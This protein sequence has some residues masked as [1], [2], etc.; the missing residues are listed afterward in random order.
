[1]SHLEGFKLI[2]EV[3]P[4]PISAANGILAKDN[5]FSFSSVSLSKTQ[6]TFILF[7][8]LILICQTVML[9][10]LIFPFVK[11]YAKKEK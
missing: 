2:K 8:Y 4:E 7:T 9:L 1:M 11:T 10:E 5:K 6:P 3:Y